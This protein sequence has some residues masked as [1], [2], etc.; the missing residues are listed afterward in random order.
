MSAA[1]GI[2]TL[3][4]VDVYYFNGVYFHAVW[5]MDSQL[6]VQLSNGY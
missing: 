6:S 3:C 2:L 5:G 4:L 1:I